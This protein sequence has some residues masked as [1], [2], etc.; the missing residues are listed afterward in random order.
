M[1]RLFG[2]VCCIDDYMKRHLKKTNLA[3][4]FITEKTYGVSQM[5]AAAQLACIMTL[6]GYATSF[7]SNDYDDSE[8]PIF[9]PNTKISVLH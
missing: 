7:I 1:V 9:T 2:A 3:V 4:C 5:R 8:E 6:V